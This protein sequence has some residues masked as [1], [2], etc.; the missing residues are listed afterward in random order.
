[1]SQHPTESQ[2]VL[3]AAVKAKME[4]FGME[5]SN[6]QVSLAM[7]MF[8]F[9]QERAINY[10][11]EQPAA[12]TPASTPAPTPAPTPATPLTEDRLPELVAPEEDGGSEEDDDEMP[13]LFDT[14]SVADLNPAAPATP[15]ASA[16]PAAPAVTTAVTTAATT[17]TT[18]NTTTNNNPQHSHT[19]PSD[20]PPPLPSSTTTPPERETKAPDTGSGVGDFWNA[21]VD[22][23]LLSVEGE[24][25]DQSETQ[26]LP[27]ASYEYTSASGLNRKDFAGVSYNFLDN[28]QKLNALQPIPGRRTPV[29]FFN[30]LQYHVGMTSKMCSVIDPKINFYTERV[31]DIVVAVCEKIANDDY[32]SHQDGYLDYIEGMDVSLH[33]LDKAFNAMGVENSSQWAKDIIERWEARYEMRAVWYCQQCTFRNSRDCKTCGMCGHGVPVLLKLFKNYT[34]APRNNSNRDYRFQSIVADLMDMHVPATPWNALSRGVSSKLMFENNSHLDGY[35]HDDKINLSRQPSVKVLVNVLK[36][37][38]KGL[39]S[40]VIKDLTIAYKIRSPLYDEELR[41]KVDGPVNIDGSDDNG[42]NGNGNGTNVGTKEEGEGEEEE[43]EKEDGQFRGETKGGGSRASASRSNNTTTSAVTSPAFKETKTA[44]EMH[45]IDLGLGEYLDNVPEGY[46]DDSS[47]LHYHSLYVNQFKTLLSSDAYATVCMFK[48]VVRHLVTVAC[49]KGWYEILRVLVEDF[50]IDPNWST[51]LKWASKTSSFVPDIRT[52]PPLH[53]AAASGFTKGVQLLLK[54]GADVNYVLLSPNEQESAVMVA[55]HGGWA[56]TVRALVVEYGATYQTDL[57]AQLEIKMQQ[58]DYSIRKLKRKRLK[59]QQKRSGSESIGSDEFILKS[60]ES[61]K[62][63]LRH[64]HYILRRRTCAHCNKFKHEVVQLN[65]AHETIYGDTVK[66]GAAAKVK[67]DDEEEGEEEEEKEQ[68]KEKKDEE[69]KKAGEVTVVPPGV[70]IQWKQN[71]LRKC[72]CRMEYYC[73]RKCQEA[74]WNAVHRDNCLAHIR[75]ILAEKA[76]KDEQLEMEEA[77]RMSMSKNEA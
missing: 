31:E 36:D 30:R 39:R 70:Q 23:H 42:G 48:E 9:N 45:R 26:K 67:E 24:T 29:E 38:L 47:L 19:P 56:K 75:C 12:P 11:L 3:V 13:A 76:H 10:L 43:E 22:N 28:Y 35:P 14:A 44:K 34:R 57:L 33:W 59:E 66:N 54:Y 68:K 18:N 4:M 21:S 41:R 60:V 62:Q 27:L 52:V 17:T 7:Q 1:M 15:A 32:A 8:D 61:A 74:R 49:S 53:F 51:G 50:R 72:H 46:C 16:A 73:S 20:A 55:A 71:V 40:F 69:D 2:F 5:H 25:K 65:N 63:N 37:G 77:L 64:A 58:V 6:A